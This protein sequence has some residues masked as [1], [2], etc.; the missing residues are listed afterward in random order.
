[1]VSIYE[2]RQEIVF[3][4][5]FVGK[6]LKTVTL[7]DGR[8]RTL[9]LTPML[10]T[11]VPVVELKDTGHRSYMGTTARI[12]SSTTINGNLMVRIVDVDD[13]EA[14]RPERRSPQPTF[15]PATSL[16]SIPEFVPAGFTQGLEILNNTTTPMDFVTDVLS[17]YAGLSLEKA[18]EAMLAIH[19]R[20]G[21][22]L[23]TAS[24]EE[25]QRI[26][27][28]VTADAAQHGYPLVC[29]AVG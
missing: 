14:G 12:A 27:A 7:A 13:L 17:T 19:T 28:L 21:V 25:A 9:E 6:Y 24:A 16:M 29:R 23:P 4:E 26:A 3:A 22:L 8:T 18:R 10:Q 20:G 5:E 15:A 1:M 11:G 2:I